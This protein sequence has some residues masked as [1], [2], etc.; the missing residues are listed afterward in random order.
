MEREARVLRERERI[1]KG[2]PER[3]HQRRERLGKLFVRDRLKLFLDS[4]QL[5]FEEGLFAR[6]L[7]PE[8]PADGL[9][10]GLGTINGRQVFIIANDYTVK[11]GSLGNMGREKQVRTQER[12]MKARKPL[13]YLIDGSGG[14]IDEI[15][16]FHSD[17]Y[18]GGR[19]FYN[20]SVMSGA[21][22]QI[23]VL[24]GPC[25]AG[26]AY[27]PVFCDFTIMMKD[28]AAMAI[29]SPRM[30]EMVTGEKISMSELGGAEMHARISGSV[31]LI[32]ESEEHA[33][34]LVKKL[35]S[36][37]PDHFEAPVPSQPPRD[38]ARDPA[39]IDSIIPA[40][41]YTPYD[42]HRL[43]EAI[44]DED[45]F[46]EIKP[47][48]ARELVTGFARIEGRTVGIV[49]N[50]PAVRTG[51]IF[52]ESSDKGAEF[53]WICDAYNIPLVFLC[54]TPGYMA[55]SHV[56]REGILRRG[57]K[58]IFATAS[59]TVPKVTIVVR[60]AYGA[61]IYAMCGPAYEPETTL[62]LPS[63]EM[64]IM[65][66]EA[67]INAV[68]Y[69]RIAA[70]EDP[71]ERERYVHEL[72]EAYREQYDIFRLTHELVPDD[73][74]PPSA[75]RREIAARLSVYAEKEINL[76]RRKHGTILS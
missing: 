38:P 52:P 14:R 33:A 7:D 3:G 72:R 54:D 20:Q 51:A 49:A 6:N 15:G 58:F 1:M 50:Q 37:L 59:A 30:V 40:D 5:D 62:A 42:V 55:G 35:L 21:I 76:P 31:D 2:G 32:A 56:E 11:A 39:E 61:G 75:I 18:K 17:R 9:I 71:E 43:I 73:I 36:Y 53:V 65:G 69:N 63:A 41:R 22:P 8:L 74:I 27:T 16:G 23:C 64:A 28:N 12:A 66:P 60:K 47:D 13:L 68:Y 29:A 25:F 26:A 45:S 48:Y 10:T 19:T 70:I 67:A 57:R 34:E 46:F 24:Y 44:V 4:G